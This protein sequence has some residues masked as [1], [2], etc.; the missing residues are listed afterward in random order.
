MEDSFTPKSDSIL[1]NKI[2]IGDVEQIKK[3]LVSGADLSIPDS[4]WGMTPMELAVEK[5]RVDIVQL[6]LDFGDSP[7]SV[8]VSSPLHLA[9]QVG[10]SEIVF[11][12]LRNGAYV[13]FQ[14]EDDWTPLFE[15]AQ[16]GHIEVVKLLVD[17]GANPN[18]I[19]IYERKPIWYAGCKGFIE[20]VEYLSQYVPSSEYME[21]FQEATEG[22]GAKARRKRERRQM[23]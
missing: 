1:H 18:A 13:D 10:S 14:H 23:H 21:A 17:A 2:E 20:V 16:A 3:V 9:S 4:Y 8:S 22:V 19:D 6:L 15:A 11:L 7:N 12:L 5:K